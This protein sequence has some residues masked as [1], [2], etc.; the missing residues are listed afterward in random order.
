[1][2]PIHLPCPDMAGC[3]NFEPE[4]TQSSLNRLRLLKAKHFPVSTIERKPPR[5][6]IRLIFDEAIYGFMR[7]PSNE[8]RD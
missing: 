7:G 5:Q 2:H 6:P 3:T 1:M 8:S 4:K